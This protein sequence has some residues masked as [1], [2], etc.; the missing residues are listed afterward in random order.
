MAGEHL[1]GAKQDRVVNA[2]YL[3][4]ERSR[5]HIPVSCVEAGRWGYRS[6]TFRGSG[7]SSHARLRKLMAR[8][9]MASYRACHAPLSDQGEVWAEVARK[10]EHMQSPSASSALFQAYLN[11]DA[12]LTDV[13][14]KVEV[15]DDANGV[16][17]A[18]GGRIA[19]M[20][21]FDLPATLARLLP[22]IVRAY[23]IDAMEES[24]AG[25]VDRAAVEKWLRSA[26]AARM[27]EYDSPGL[28]S[29]VR[30]EG[31]VVIGAALIV[32]EV[33]VHVEL[34]PNDQP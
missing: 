20:D 11:H 25:D 33:P 32:D 23:A 1:L 2:S 17:F 34:F 14:A 21:L 15:P 3:I 27:E 26:S 10:L 29:D 31:D 16:A 6:R 19:G 12:G 13:L 24:G 30:V 4:A 18:Y 8:H 9:A 5:L 28:G 7:S 22:K